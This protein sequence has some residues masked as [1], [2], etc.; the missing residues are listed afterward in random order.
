[1][2][3]V[4]KFTVIVWFFVDCAEAYIL[5]KK[6]KNEKYHAIRDTRGEKKFLF[7]AFC[8]EKM[9]IFANWYKILM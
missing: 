4:V 9:C 8:N 2:L 6:N 1:M 7:F 5:I 3:K